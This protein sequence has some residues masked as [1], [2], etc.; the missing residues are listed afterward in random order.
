[1]KKMLA[2]LLAVSMV[3]SASMAFAADTGKITVTVNG[4]T[5]KTD[6]APVME[7]DRI[8]LPMR[9]IFETLGCNVSYRVNDGKQFVTAFR[10]DKQVV[11]EIGKN[12]ITV[13]G[14]AKALDVAAKI[15]NDRTLVPVR[16]VSEA[17]DADVSWN[18][19]TSTAEITTKQ[20]EHKI[21]SVTDEKAV[22]D[23]DG[24][25]LMYINY[26]YP[27]IENKDNNEYI[28][29]INDEYKAYAEKFVA[30]AEE[31]TEDAKY[32][33]NE[34]G[35]DK[36][37]PY[38]FN[39][40]YNVHMDRNGIL[41]ITNY[42]F[43]DLGGAHPNTER[44][45]KS[46]DLKNAKELTLSDVVIGDEDEMHTMVYDVFVKY[47]E[48]NSSDFSA[49]A[50]SELDK[51]CDNVKFY[52]EDNNLVLYF[53][54]YQVS[55]YAAGYPTVYL[56]YSKDFFKIDVSAGD[57]EANTEE[58]ATVD[59]TKSDETKSEDEVKTDETKTEETKTEAETEKVTE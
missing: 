32:L 59:E 11:L 7:N 45:S 24:T 50:A 57:A 26:V 51:E 12:E 52:L 49:E 6:V 14:E 3:G 25:V 55:S 5:V 20:G 15:E 44:S 9:A 10:G 22:K 1:M 46:F 37:R 31:K 28:A 27:V 34:M 30:D 8:L 38:E 23:E 16:A 19:E 13:D 17:M 21:T 42:E 39:L 40:S 47:F 18:G 53:D 54:V 36:F 58:N 4:E 35:K 2:G 56:K 33:L 43:Y 48:E 29:K 41:S